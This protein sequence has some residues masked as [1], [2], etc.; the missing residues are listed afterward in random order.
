MLPTQSPLAL[1]WVDRVA[2][3]AESFSGPDC[4]FVFERLR[5]SDQEPL[6]VFFSFLFFLTKSTENTYVEVSQPVALELSVVGV[7]DTHQ[8]LGFLD[9]L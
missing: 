3:I 9:G 8:Q 5:G 7:Y 6:L 1:I 4:V 2:W